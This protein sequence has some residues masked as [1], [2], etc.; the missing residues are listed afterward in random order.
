LQALENEWRLIEL[1]IAMM[2]APTGWMALALR[3]TSSRF[4]EELTD[5]RD[6]ETL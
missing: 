6:E 1:M 2:I 4:K 5:G 3:T